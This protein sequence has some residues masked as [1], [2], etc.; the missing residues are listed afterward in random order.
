VVPYDDVALVQ[1]NI[2]QKLFNKKI[3]RGRSVIE[4][5]LGLMKKN[6]FRELLDT[7]ELDVRIIPDVF[8]AY[9]LLHILIVGQRK[10]NVDQLM[11]V[12]EVEAMKDAMP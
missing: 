6:K 11:E 4:N 3:N 10:V 5:A 7:I 2:L 8:S 1:R 9:C 12:L